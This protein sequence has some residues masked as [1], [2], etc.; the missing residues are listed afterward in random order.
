M[1]RVFR[2]ADE[3]HTIWDGTGAALLGGRWNSA[4]TPVIYG[5]LSF[6]CAMLEILAH[7]GIGRV[8][9]TQRFSVAELP[10]AVPIER[11]ATETLP[12]GWDTEDSAGARALGDA[13]VAQRRS[14]LLLVPSVVA[15]L[16]WTAVIN[17]AHPDFGRLQFSAP[18]RVIWDRRLFGP[19][20]FSPAP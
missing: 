12:E 19:A 8:P 1:T 4:G 11:H 6:A 5:S 18:E 3:R 20:P 9:H 14:V 10:D 7:A 15:R 16:E 13:W 17:P 2:I